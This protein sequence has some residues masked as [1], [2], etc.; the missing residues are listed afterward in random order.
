MK[1]KKWDIF[2]GLTA[3]IVAL[4]MAL[5]FGLQSGMGAAAG[6]YGAIILGIVA[7]LLGGTPTQVSGPTWPMTVVSATVVAAAIAVMGNIESGL[8]LIIM[9]FALAGICQILFGVLKVGQ[10]IKY[11]PYPVVSWFMTGIG[12]IIIVLQI[13]PLL[14][15]QSPKGIIAVLQNI[16]TPLSAI[17]WRSVLLAALTVII[18]YGLPK[19]T[20]KIPSTLA[21]LVIVTI[22][23]VLLG[24]NVPSIGTIPQWL[25]HMQGIFSWSI[26]AQHRHFILVSGITL[27]ALGSIDSL[28]TS[29][30]ADTMTKTKHNSNKELIGQGIGNTIAAVFGGIPG[31]WATMRT[32]VNIKAGA[33]TRLSG[34]IHGI[35]LWAILLWLWHYVQYVPTAVLAAILITVWIG[36]IDYR[37]IKHITHIPRSDAIIMIVVLVLT[38]FVDLIEAVGIGMVLAALLFMKKM[39][40]IAHAETEVWMF[41]AHEQEEVRKDES[42]IPTNI[43][44]SV[45]IKHLYWPLFFGFT[46]SFKKLVKETPDIKIVIFRMKKVPFIDQSWLYALEEAILDLEMRWIMVVCTWLKK[47]PEALLR[48]IG[49]IPNLISEDHVFSTMKSCITWLKKTTV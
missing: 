7:A 49:I 12:V 23:A 40:D 30:V 19:L 6:L 27:A 29:V 42:T 16:M 8:P 32:L 11:I 10:Y 4:P 48:S 13:F 18:I 33:S 47:Q 3:G 41:D 45:Y 21:A 38:V 2:G 35:V 46:E 39:G 28:L 26:L 9:T 36:I 31:A 43:R 15:H 24:I 1:V 25:P 34:V 44:E 5:A 20:K 14:G 37:G 22:I 17:N